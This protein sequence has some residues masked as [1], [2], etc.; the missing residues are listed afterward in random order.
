MI[1]NKNLVKN[2]EYNGELNQDINTFY[3]LMVEAKKTF[4]TWWKAKELININDYSEHVAKFNEFITTLK[5]DETKIINGANI[6]PWPFLKQLVSDFKKEVNNINEEIVNDYS[7]FYPD[8]TKAPPIMFSEDKINFRIEKVNFDFS[9][10]INF[11]ELSQPD[12]WT[13]RVGYY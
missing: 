2:E 8:P 9:Y 11:K 12:G 13:Q 3:K 6:G 1:R 10:D 4:Q 5:E 7:N